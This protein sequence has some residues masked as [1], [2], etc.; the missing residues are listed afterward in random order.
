MEITKERNELRKGDLGDIL[1]RLEDHLRDD[2]ITNQGLQRNN[3]Q[4][5]QKIFDLNQQLSEA[6]FEYKR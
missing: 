3:Q 4:L 5:N 2:K 1:L 6:K